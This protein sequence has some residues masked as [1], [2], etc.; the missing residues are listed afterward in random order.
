MLSKIKR[1]RLWSLQNER[2]ESWSRRA[3]CSDVC[4]ATSVASRAAGQT[5]GGSSFSPAREE[6]P[7]E[8]SLF[9][10]HQF[11]ATARTISVFDL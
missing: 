8:I 10:L 6:N 2:E 1:E 9:L 3:F 4:A 7:N 5:V 11:V